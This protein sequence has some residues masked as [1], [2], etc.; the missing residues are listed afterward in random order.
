V[1]LRDEIIALV[2]RRPGLT[3]RQIALVVRRRRADV[4]AGLREV[5]RE[6]ILCWEQVRYGARSWHPFPG[7]QAHVPGASVSEPG[8][9]AEGDGSATPSPAEGDV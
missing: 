4:L 3:T 9:Q 8:A 1:S 5:E 2:K 6:R 7:G